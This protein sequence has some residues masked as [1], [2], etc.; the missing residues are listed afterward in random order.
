MKEILAENR[1][2]MTK[3]LFERGMRLTLK[4]SF[5]K[6]VRRTL[7]AL[8]LLSALLAAIARLRDVG[9]V[10]LLPELIVLA[11]AA[12]WVCFWVGVLLPRR[13]IRR[14]WQAM[15]E[16]GT[17]EAQRI[18]LFYPDRL[19]TEVDGKVTAAEYKEITQILQDGELIVLVT[20]SRTAFLLER[21]G[22]VRG[23][24]EEILCLIE[25]NMKERKSHD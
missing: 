8:V 12:L 19:E 22:F 15:E 10:W 2:T 3:P 16:T 18:T 1:Y 23:D 17:E 21:R 13:R 7:L 11:A 24:G 4:E 5:G 9:A 6:L 20:E 14:L 25:Q